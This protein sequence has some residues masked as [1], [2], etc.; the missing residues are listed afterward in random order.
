[1]NPTPQEIAEWTFSDD[2]HRLANYTT[3][4]EILDDTFYQHYFAQSDPFFAH[5]ITQF[6]PDVPLFVIGEVIQ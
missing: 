1:M 2:M 3:L 4:E 6:A 5:N